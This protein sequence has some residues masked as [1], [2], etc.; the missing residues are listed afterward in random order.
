M[1]IDYKK[2]KQTTANLLV[3]IRKVKTT[4]Q[5][6]EVL[7]GGY[8]SDVNEK[9]TQDAIKRLNTLSAQNFDLEMKD[10]EM[11]YYCALAYNQTAETGLVLG[12]K[13]DKDFASKGLGKDDVEKSAKNAW[14]VGV[15]I[16]N[17]VLNWSTI[18]GVFTKEVSE[19]YKGFSCS[20]FYFTKSI[21][22]YDPS[23][24]KFNV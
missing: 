2:Y 9:Q 13:W 14:A 16:L 4:S 7:F 6:D 5:V 17:A 12:R 19:L 8:Y 1:L 24:T 22:D 15:P 20:A 11:A 21:N 3:Q 18:K 10:S 23:I